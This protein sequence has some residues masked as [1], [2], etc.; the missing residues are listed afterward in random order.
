MKWMRRV[1][2]RLLDEVGLAPASRVELVRKQL[3]KAER[4]TAK[5]ELMAAR[6]AEE[7]EAANRRLRE[8]AANRRLREE[9]ANRRLREEAEAA[10]RRA[11]VALE[12]LRERLPAVGRTATQAQEQ[13]MAIEVKLKILEGA[14]TVLDARFRTLASGPSGGVWWA[15][16][17]GESSQARPA[18]QLPE[19]SDG[20]H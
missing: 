10:N 5:A 2:A 12:T 14:I 16:D 8:E 11:A 19:V 9:A 4:A 7:A 1:A 13:S 6:A 20:T 15:R 3:H 17:E 18:V